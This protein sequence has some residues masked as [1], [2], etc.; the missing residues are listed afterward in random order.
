E[1]L[2]RMQS[3]VPRLVEQHVAQAAAD[4][5]AEDAVE[6]QILDVA[7]RPA[8]LRELRQ[9]CAPP[10]EEEKKREADQVCD[11]VPVDRQR[12]AEARQVERDR[13]ELRMPQHAEIIRG[14]A[15]PS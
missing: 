2:E 8:T 15:R 7:P 9:P 3:V 13:V 14:R 11:A 10:G 12:D 1:D 4:D 6:E 5:G